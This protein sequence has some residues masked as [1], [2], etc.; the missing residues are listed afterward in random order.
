[1]VRSLHSDDEVGQ[2]VSNGDIL[3]RLLTAVAL[4]VA[5]SASAQHAELSGL[6]TA[7]GHG[8]R[9]V[10]IRARDPATGA[11]RSATTSR[12]GTFVIAG[13]RPGTYIVTF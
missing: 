9:D 4:S 10:T 5:V 7:N 3:H 8:L 2:Q 1:M 11:Q 12:E 6:A 13:L